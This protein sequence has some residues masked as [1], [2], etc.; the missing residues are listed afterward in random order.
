MIVLSYG[1]ENMMISW[2]V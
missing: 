1:K 2:A